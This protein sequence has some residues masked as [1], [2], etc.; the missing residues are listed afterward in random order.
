[1]VRAA[2]PLAA[3]LALCAPGA[4]AA[5][6]AGA[7]Q[8]AIRQ[9]NDDYVRAFLS[10]DVARFRSLLAADF[11]GVLADGRV[12]DKAGF[13]VQAAQLPDARD[14][15]LHDV[16]IRVFGDTALVGAAVTYR[17]TDG[18]GVRTRYTSVYLRRAGRWEIVWV[19]WT[20]VTAP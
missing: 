6:P 1:M 14:L 8:S 5:E 17:R 16:V 7:D 15:R 19:Q 4:G 3:F 13:L 18:S 11:V 20:R 10:C 12:I 2:L 9:M